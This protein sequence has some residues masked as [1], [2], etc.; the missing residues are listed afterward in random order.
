MR[1]IQKYFS[2]V[3]AFRAGD[4][5][6]GECP[7]CIVGKALRF[8]DDVAG[9]LA[10]LPHKFWSHELTCL[11][12]LE[13]MLPLASQ[14]GRGECGDTH[15]PEKMDQRQPS[16]GR[17]KVATFTQDIAIAEQSLDDSGSGSWSSQTALAHC[18]PEFLVLN[19]LARPLHS[20]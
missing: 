4:I 9:K 15:V 14:L 11:H 20:T 1:Q 13:L 7:F 17:G 10:D 8:G 16:A 12:A 18:F 6:I 3:S 2:P 5:K 19:Q